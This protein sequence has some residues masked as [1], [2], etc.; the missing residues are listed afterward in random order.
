MRSGFLSSRNQ[1]SG[2]MTGGSGI[3]KW[4]IWKGH[5]DY[6]VVALATA[7]C[8]SPFRMVC[9]LKILCTA[10]VFTK[11]TYYIC[12]HPLKGL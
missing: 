10:A 11:K 12:P 4:N 6:Q 3:L 2:K 5:F 7:I 8:C 9:M 1:V